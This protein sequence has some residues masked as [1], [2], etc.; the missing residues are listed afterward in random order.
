MAAY[1]STRLDLCN[2]IHQW[3]SPS[4]S[5]ICPFSKFILCRLHFHN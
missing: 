1:R 3:L 2:R 5:T 4:Y